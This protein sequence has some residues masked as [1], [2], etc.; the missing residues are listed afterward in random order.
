MIPTT[1]LWQYAPSH[2]ASDPTSTN[3]SQCIPSTNGS[4]IFPWHFNNDTLA[5]YIASFMHQVV[6]LLLYLLIK[7]HGKSSFA[8]KPYLP[9]CT[10]THFEVRSYRVCKLENCACSVKMLGNINSNYWFYIL[11]YGVWKWFTSII[12]A[13]NQVHVILYAAIDFVIYWICMQ[14][15]IL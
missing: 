13:Y 6:Y 14:R 7:V 3:E 12:T 9:F 11:R 8:K 15:L 2:K 4:L 5:I 1:I 10:I